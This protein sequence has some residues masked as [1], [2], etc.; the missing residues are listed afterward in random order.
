LKV[1]LV[2]QYKCD[3][4]GKR[5]YSAMH[6][7]K[8]ERHC[9]MNPNRV[10]RMCEKNGTA[11]QEMKDLL[12][13]LPSPVKVK[14]TCWMSELKNIEQFEN[15]DEINKAIDSLRDKVESCPVCILAAIRQKGIPVPATDFD[16]KK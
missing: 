11:Q 2:N 4:C 8:H 10:C 5:G 13:I 14:S 9:T 6:M 12:C 15:I 3:F 1:K 7:R 16:F